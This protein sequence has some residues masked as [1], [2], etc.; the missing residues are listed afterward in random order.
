MSGATS[1]GSMYQRRMRGVRAPSA[2]APSTIVCSRSERTEARTTRITRGISG[3]TSA[4]ITLRTLAFIRAIRASASRMAGI[5]MRPSI[6]RI[7]IAS[8]RR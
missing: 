1:A 7:M 4:M 8:R 2:R 3:I 6:T 5:A